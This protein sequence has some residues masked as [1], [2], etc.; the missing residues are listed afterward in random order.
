MKSWWWR[1]SWSRWWWRQRNPPLRSEVGDQS[2]LEILVFDG[3]STL[4]HEKLHALGCRFFPEYKDGPNELFERVHE[5]QMVLHHAA[6]RWA[7]MVHP[8][9]RLMGPLISIVFCG[10]FPRIYFWC[11]LHEKDRKRGF[12]LKTSSV[13]AVFIQVLVQ[14]WTKHLAKW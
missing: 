14:F 9:L 11:F 7:C 13:L 5:G 3:D 8:I 10:I 6:W 4:F 2:G 12:L 1:S